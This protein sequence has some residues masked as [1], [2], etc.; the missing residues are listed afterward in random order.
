MRRQAREKTGYQLVFGYCS[1]YCALHPLNR[2][3]AVMLEFHK[4]QGP[5]CFAYA[6]WNLG[7]LNE[8]QVRE[9]E[10][11][12]SL[13]NVLNSDYNLDVQA[14]WSLDKFPAY[15]QWVEEVIKSGGK[16]LAVDAFGSEQLH[17]PATG[18]HLAILRMHIATRWGLFGPFEPEHM[19]GHAVSVEDGLI[20]D[21]DYDG[22]LETEEEFVRRYKNEWGTDVEFV[23]FFPVP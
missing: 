8:E 10:D 9:Y 12:Y 16:A 22:T 1:F 7:V 2:W 15:G 23:H 18:K 20:L 21:P 3:G 13:A 17:V 11:I 4:Q 19:E 6:L 5:T 14:K